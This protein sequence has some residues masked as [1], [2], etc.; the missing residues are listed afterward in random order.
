LSTPYKYLFDGEGFSFVTDFGVEYNCYFVEYGFLLEAEDLKHIKILS[1]NIE[2]IY[3]SLKPNLDP[4]VKE[5]VKEIITE[6][7][8][9]PEDVLIFICDSVDQRQ[10]SRARKF[11]AWFNQSENIKIE[12]YDFKTVSDGVEILN[13]LL[14]HFDHPL[15]IRI[16]Q[17]WKELND[18][19]VLK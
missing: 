14:I 9:T 8:K 12:K 17:E 3:R 2:P 6:F 15:K 19:S 16:V 4:K 10:K 1:F 7:F 11:D 18:N 5:T 13:S